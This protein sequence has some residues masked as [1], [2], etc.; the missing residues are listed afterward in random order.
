MYHVPLAFQCIYGRSD[1]GCEDGYGKEGSGIIGGWRLPGLLYTND[2]NLCGESVED[3]R[4]MV[5]QFVEVCRRRGL[6]VNAGKSRV[7]L[8]NGLECEVYVGRIRLEH[9]SEILNIWDVFWTNQVH[10][11][12]S[13]VGK[14]RVGGGL[15]VLLGLQ[16]MLRICSLS[17]LESC[18]KHCLHLSLCMAV[19]QCYGRE[20]NLELG[21]YSLTTS[22]VFYVLGG[23]IE[24]RMHG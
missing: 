5:G 2:L 8:L 13:V 20:R 16:L 19:R 17:V 4:A 23:W 1:E 3:P 9:V 15:Q 22:E 18:M 11:R 6:R 12:H 10:T 21:V 24:S 14:W 7:I